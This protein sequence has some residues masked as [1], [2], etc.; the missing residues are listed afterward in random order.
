MTVHTPL[1]IS[2]KVKVMKNGVQFICYY[3]QL[4]KSESHLYSRYIRRTH[5]ILKCFSKTLKTVYSEKVGLLY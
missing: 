3:G 1:I 5:S 4:M 2:T